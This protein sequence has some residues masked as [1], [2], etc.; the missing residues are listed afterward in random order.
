MGEA[1]TSSGMHTKKKVQI[2]K[3]NVKQLGVSRYYEMQTPE[4]PTPQPMKEKI[5]M[6]LTVAPIK[7][8]D[9]AF[10]ASVWL[11]TEIISNIVQNMVK[12]S[13][14]SRTLSKQ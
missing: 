4:A 14:A 10:I 1:T 3:P 5:T 12:L 11:L 2:P 7:L 6:K 9:V 8:H 13:M